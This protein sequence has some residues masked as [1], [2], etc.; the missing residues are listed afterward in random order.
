M[1]TDT[2]PTGFT[3]PRILRPKIKVGDFV[4]VPASKVSH[5]P[6]Y[7]GHVVYISGQNEGRS[8]CLVRSE[9]A[10]NGKSGTEWEHRLRIVDTPINEKLPDEMQ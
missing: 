10:P 1:T 3:R 7:C 4:R 2:T 9:Q 8:L 6:S 5:Y